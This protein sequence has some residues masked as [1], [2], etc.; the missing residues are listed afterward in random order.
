MVNVDNHLCERNEYSLK[1]NLG[2]SGHSLLLQERNST[3]DLTFNLA[4]ARV[5]GD[6]VSPPIIFLQEEENSGTTGAIIGAIVGGVGGTLLGI[7]IGESAYDDFTGESDK[8]ILTFGVV[9][10]VV[11]LIGGAFLGKHIGK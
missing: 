2:L 11:G 7:A 8:E 5:V 4:T 10:G 9:G 6:P 1:M 3:A